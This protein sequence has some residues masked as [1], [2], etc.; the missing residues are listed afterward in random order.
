[1]DAKI[2]EIA[3]KAA[4]KYLI[5]ENEYN[6]TGTGRKRRAPGC[7]SAKNFMINWDPGSGGARRKRIPDGYAKVP[8]TASAQCT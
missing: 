1:M 8:R 7:S 5:L 4:R 6:A 3:D 2:R